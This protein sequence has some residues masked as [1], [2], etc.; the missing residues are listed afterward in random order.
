MDIWTTVAVSFGFGAFAGLAKLVES[1]RELSA[2][3][4][5]GVVLS[6]GLGG[7]VM[8]LASSTVCNVAVKQPLDTGSLIMAALIGGYG[9]AGK[10]IAFVQR[11]DEKP[12]DGE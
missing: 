11:K 8:G 7:L 10:A 2:R 4:Y 6:C 1:K 12:R 9:G 3:A 5:S